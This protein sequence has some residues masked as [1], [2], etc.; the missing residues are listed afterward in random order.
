[1]MSVTN[2]PLIPNNVILNVVMLSV[3]AP[4]G[5]SDT[6]MVVKKMVP[7]RFFS[8]VTTTKTG[9]CVF[10]NHFHLRGVCTSSKFVRTA[11][12]PL[13]AISLHYA[14]KSALCHLVWIVPFS[15]QY[16]I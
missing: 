7:V 5:T 14:I 15:L 4:S 11:F 8:S 13:C 12:S 9:F 1:M 16:A 10:I 6:A 2:K 3:V